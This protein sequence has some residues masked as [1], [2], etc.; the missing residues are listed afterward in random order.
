[1]AFNSK[2][3]NTYTFTK[4]GIV[5]VRISSH[6]YDNTCK[7]GILNEGKCNYSIMNN[8]ITITGKI[9]HT[10]WSARFFTGEYDKNTDHGEKS[11]K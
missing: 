9:R 2:N 6:E 1:M 5:N 8:T 3:T 7:W 4:D 10:S 11:F